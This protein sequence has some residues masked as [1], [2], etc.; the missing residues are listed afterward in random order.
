MKFLKYI[1]VLSIAFSFTAENYSQNKINIRKI[2]DLYGQGARTYFLAANR[3]SFGVSAYTN[4]KSEV[5][6]STGISAG[7]DFLEI[8]F[9]ISYGLTNRLELFGGINAYTQSYNFSG[10]KVTGV[11]DANIGLRYK[12]YES[13]YFS[14]AFQTIVKIPTA[15]KS[16]ELGTGKVDFHFG[17]GHS[18]ASKY[19]GY[20]VSLEAGLL[21]RRDLP[22]TGVNIPPILRNGIDSIKKSYNYTFE[23]EVGF[24]LGPS[25]YPTSKS[26]IYTGYA[27]SRNTRL[28]YNTSSVYGGVGYSPSNTL[29]L[30]LGTSYGLGED[31]ALLV[32]FGLT[33][34]ILKKMY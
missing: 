13:E 16:K 34:S 10:D 14:N 28:N 8:P 25:V 18:Y 4:D 3:P 20:D 9:D 23:P 30:S 15:S 6:I 24:S 1:V 26:F 29:S 31:G 32:S 7:E 2:L 33:V 12:L 27:F 17:L 21:Y 22:G 5:Q 19:W 11:G